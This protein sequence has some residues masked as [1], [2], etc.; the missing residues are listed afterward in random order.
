[1]TGHRELIVARNPD[2]KSSLPYLIGLPL[3]DGLLWLKAKESWPR[4]SRVYCHPLDSAPNVSQLDVI[5]RH[6]VSVCVRRGNAI[7]VL[8]VRGSQKR[9]QFVLVNYRGRRLIFWQ[10]PKAARAAR[11]GLRIPGGEAP[12]TLFYRD[13]RERYGY[14]FS[15]HGAKV[16]RR[17]LPVGDYAVMNGDRMLCVVERKTRD[18][19]TAALVDGTLGFALI[20]L[21]AVPLAAVVIECKYSEILRHSYVRPGFVPLLVARLQARYPNVPIEFLESKKIAEEWTY[22]FLRAGYAL[23]DEGEPFLPFSAK[24]S[25]GQR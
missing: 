8:L 12:E 2:L 16:E 15:T 20:E 10:T 5:R 9:S 3:P 18:D 17:A 24:R 21:S 7:D 11:P 6:P 4:A 1:M 23:R 13:T 19:F 14:T 22:Q 25:A